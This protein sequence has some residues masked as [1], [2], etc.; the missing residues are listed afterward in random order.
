[1]NPSAKLMDATLIDSVMGYCALNN[2]SVSSLARLS[3]GEVSFLLSEVCQHKPEWV[4]ASQEVRHHMG[5]CHEECHISRIQTLMEDWTKDGSPGAKPVVTG[6]I[7]PF[8][9]NSTKH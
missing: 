4:W 8:P 1:M 7:I 9:T 2:V 5:I 3:F 6:K